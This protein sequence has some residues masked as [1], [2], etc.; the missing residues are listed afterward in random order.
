MTTTVKVAP[1]IL[2]ADFGRLADEVRA[3]ER[4]GADLVH[5]DVMDGRFVPNL[6]IGPL[7]VEAVKRATSLPLD[8]HLMIVEPERYVAD[9]AKAGASF[10][11]VHQEACP[12]LHRTLQQ[13]RAAGARPGVVLNPATPLS[14]IEEVLG[15]VDLVLLMSVNP[16]FGGQAFI[17]ATVDKV[18]RLRALLDARG[19]GHVDVEVDGGI[20]ADTAR[21]VVAAGASV[22]VAGNAVFKSPDYAR[23]IAALRP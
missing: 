1:S 19:L 9:F 21:Q 20:N 23:A 5:V 15:D 3:I 22:L 11:T 4:A 8:V 13:I 16:G 17:P 7:V 18:R 10:I 12:H 6:T 2:S 14:A